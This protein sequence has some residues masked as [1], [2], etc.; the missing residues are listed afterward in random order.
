[1]TR[2]SKNKNFIISVIGRD[3]RETPE[4]ETPKADIPGSPSQKEDSENNRGAKKHR[5]KYRIEYTEDGPKFWTL[6]QR[7]GYIE[8]RKFPITVEQ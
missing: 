8:A 4:E 5:T 3:M 2:K 7:E 1:M 6:H